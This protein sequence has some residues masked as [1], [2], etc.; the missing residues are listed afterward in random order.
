MTND[1]AAFVE[2]LLRHGIRLDRDELLEVVA[3]HT[4]L[5]AHH[6]A[7]MVNSQVEALC[8]F[9]KHDMASETI[10]E[11]VYEKF[12]GGDNDAG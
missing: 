8:R 2:Y 5:M 4:E 3:G 9:I 1:E 6:G 10:A 12:K 11:A 7:Y